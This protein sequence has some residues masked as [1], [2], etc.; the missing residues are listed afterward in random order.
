LKPEEVSN[1]MRILVLT[2][3]YLPEIAA[4]S[5]RI[6]DHARYWQELGHEVTVVTCAPNFPHGK[7]F[8]GY[9]NRRIQEELLDGVRVVRVWSYMA[10][11]S[12]TVKRTLDHMSFVMSAVSACRRLPACDVILATSP[13]LFTAL[14]GYMLSRL[15]RKPWLFE[16]RDLW[17]ATIKAVGAADGRILRMLERLEMFLYRKA[18]LLVPLTHS[19]QRELAARGVP[20]EKMQVVTNGVDLQQFDRQQVPGLARHKLGIPDGAFLTGYIGTTGMCQG[21]AAVVDAAER[22]RTNP[23]LHFLIMGEGAERRALEQ[24]AREKQ[25]RNLHFADF[26]PHR[27]IADYYFALD[28]ALVHLRPDPLFRTVIPSKIFE[29]MAAGVPLLMAAEGE[30]AEIVR[31]AGCGRSVTPG[32]SAAIAKT[33]QQLAASRN[34]LRLMGMRGRQTVETSYSRRVLAQDMITALEEAIVRFH[35]GKNRAQPPHKEYAAQNRRGGGERVYRPA[36]GQAAAR[37]AA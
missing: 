23:A 15:W 17:P 9:R 2:D 25:L 19:F 20:A 24:Q 22:C 7:V 21:L 3:R 6:A 29:Y 1:P 16:I 12:G 5:F 32:D 37:R 27:E 34:E 14:G 13:P 11:N 31:K 30:S 36:S 28:L 18:D 33:V 4:P 8:E 26:V 35:G 10:E